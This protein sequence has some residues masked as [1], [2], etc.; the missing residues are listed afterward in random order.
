MT[1]RYVVD[2]IGAVVDLVEVELVKTIHYIY[3]HPLEITES[4]QQMTATPSVSVTKFPMI[5]LLTD[6]PERKGIEGV[7]SDV[8]LNLI[9]AT[10]TDRHYKAHQRYVTSFKPTLYPIYN[11]FITQLYKCSY[12][13]LVAPERVDHTKYDRLYLGRMGLYGKN[14][15]LFNDYIDAIEIE[16][17]KLKVKQQIC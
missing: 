4:L 8:T 17:L 2:L 7:Y 11:E 14:G 6:F 16:N 13:E 12:F 5:A 15:N 9:I 3:G 1:T 10:L